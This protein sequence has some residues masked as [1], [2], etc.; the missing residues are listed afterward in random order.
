V[1]TAKD[2][3]EEAI[4]TKSQDAGRRRKIKGNK[5]TPEPTSPLAIQIGHPA[6]L[7]LLCLC[8]PTSRSAIKL[9]GTRI[10]ELRSI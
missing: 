3:D 10:L 9:I 8:C 5:E 2:L 6:T 7:L 4:I 1:T